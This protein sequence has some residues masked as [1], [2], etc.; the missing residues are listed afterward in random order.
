MNWEKEMGINVQLFFFSSLL[1]VEWHESHKFLKVEF[2]FNLTTAK[3]SYETQYGFLE[4]PT[5]NNT[6]WDSARFEVSL[7]L[8]LLFFYF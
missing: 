6:S 2:P 5:H 8:Q 3:A 4:R 1:Q 7:I